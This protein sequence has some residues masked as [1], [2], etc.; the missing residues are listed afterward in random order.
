MFIEKQ[1]LTMEKKS[2]GKKVNPLIS[3]VI[4]VYNVEKYL[5]RCLDSVIEQTYRNLEIILVDDGS[6]DGSGDICE[7]YGQKDTRIKVLH[8]KNQ[9]QAS[10]RNY[11]M[12]YVHGM[13]LVFIDSDDYVS[14]CH[15]EKMFMLAKH[16]DANL[17]QCCMKKIRSD[18]KAKEKV[19]DYNVKIYTPS[20]AMKAYCYQKYFTASP[21]GKLIHISLIDNL[22]FPVGMGY[23]DAAVM[24]KVIGNAQSLVFTE[25]VM[26]YYRQHAMSTMH[27]KFSEK[28]IDRIIIAE[29]LKQYI[30]AKFPENS[31]AVNTRYI[32]ANFQLL[33]DLP[34]DK[35]YR[36]LRHEISKNIRNVRLKVI[37]DSESKIS[38]KLIAW[39]SYFG[40]PILMGLGRIYKKIYY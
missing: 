19:I 12:Q 16:Y 14:H 37:K 22:K 4:P 15:I 2:L 36:S 38:I 27:A 7:K 40:L 29:Q 30:E 6:T 33:M 5:E 25:E 10:A 24:Y 9:G 28:K 26:Y 13:Y 8:Q 32:L 35:K 21:W 39:I 23:E 17:V 31:K 34:Y 1:D 20:E 18:K 11:G 3:I